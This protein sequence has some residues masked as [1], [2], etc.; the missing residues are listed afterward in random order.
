MI[1][2]ERVATRRRTAAEKRRKVPVWWKM[3]RTMI[4]VLYYRLSMCC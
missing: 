4:A 2:A 1:G 3:P